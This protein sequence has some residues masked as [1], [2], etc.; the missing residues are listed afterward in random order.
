MTEETSFKDRIEM[1]HEFPG[2]YTFKVIG[3]NDMA[4]A[5]RVRA[6][7]DKA[8]PGAESAWSRRESAKG[9]HVSIT[10]DVVVPSADAVLAVYEQLRFVEGV[11]LVL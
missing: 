3:P 1:E 6:A 8:C 2:T 10:A 5:A 11:R 7:L 4:F 9:R